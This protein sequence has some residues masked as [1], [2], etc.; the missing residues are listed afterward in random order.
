[1]SEK[2]QETKAVA[3]YHGPATDAPA[4][5]A[6]LQSSRAVMLTA[7]RVVRLS[8]GHK[9]APNLD[10]ALLIAQAALSQGLD[11]FTE[12]H[13]WINTYTKNGVEIRDLTIM[14]HRDG[15][16]R[17]ANEAAQRAETSLSR[18][19]YYKLD[20]NQKKEFEI[21]VDALAIEARVEDDRSVKD[22]IKRAE[23]FS[24]IGFAK[25]EI[26]DKIG[27][28]PF[29]SGI[30]VVTQEEIRQV[31]TW[32]HKCTNAEANTYK[33]KGKNYKLRPLVG[34]GDCP[35]CGKPTY[36]KPP[37]WTWIERARKRAY[38]QAITP[39]TARVDADKL[40][41]VVKM[42]DMV[43]EGEWMDIT[44]EESPEELASKAAEG[45]TTLYPSSEEDED[46]K[47]QRRTPSFWR[48]DVLQAIVECGFADNDFEAAGMLSHSAFHPSVGVDPAI[49]YSKHYRAGKDEGLK[50]AEAGAKAFKKYTEEFGKGNK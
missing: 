34:Y 46:P 17:L 35:D 10:E 27:E 21:P 19:R 44:V 25:E 49:F 14:R 41:E 42:D 8:I 31:E 13:W 38:T 9:V 23:Q 26:E 47:E 1:M 16:I 32:K 22:W 39:W 4:T 18:P 36:L 33:P 6:R 43:I 40:A 48:E 3:L 7:S 15:K 20:R 50:P 12:L 11:V 2:E 29:W 45:T 30:G 24:K 5:L 28:C 37:K